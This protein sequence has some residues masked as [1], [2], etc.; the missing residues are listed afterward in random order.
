MQN[1]L[2]CSKSDEIRRSP[3]VHILQ[4]Y[5][6]EPTSYTAASDYK[7]LNLFFRKVGRGGVDSQRQDMCFL[8]NC[9]T[10]E[11]LHRLF[12]KTV[13]IVCLRR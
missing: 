7:G 3:Y 10:L 2:L 13:S 6:P 4:Q 8:P 5:L 12:L 11:L 9:E 1:P